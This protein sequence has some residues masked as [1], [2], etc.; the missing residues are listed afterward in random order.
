MG[1][2]ENPSG[3]RNPA[4]LGPPARDAK[5]R[6]WGGYPARRGGEGQ[7]VGQGRVCGK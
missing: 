6:A 4:R 5:T 2:S 3:P 7:G 1:A